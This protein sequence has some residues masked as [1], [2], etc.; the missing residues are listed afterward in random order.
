MIVSIGLAK[1]REESRESLYMYLR[2]KAERTAARPKQGSVKHFCERCLHSCTTAE[3]LERHKPVCMGQL[4]KPTRTHLPKEGE[5]KVKFKNH[6]KQMKEPF[7]VYADFHKK[8]PRVS[9]KRSGNDQN[10]GPRALQLCVRNREKRRS[11][12]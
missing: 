8:D 11:E 9:E 7:V 12:A 10:R 3:L 4:K 2:E 1:K 5:N 6:N